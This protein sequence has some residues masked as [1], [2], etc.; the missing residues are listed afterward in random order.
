MKFALVVTALV[1]VASI[2]SA[3][4]PVQPP[5]PFAASVDQLQEKLGHPAVPDTE[6]SLTSIKS[7]IVV[8]KDS[9]AAHEIESAIR[10]IESLGGKI[11]ERYTDIYKG[12]TAKIPF[13][14][15][16]D[17]LTALG[18]FNFI[19]YYEEDGEVSGYV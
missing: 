16:S 15:L 4:L 19:D 8:F 10:F 3:A 5:N 13:A 17:A 1:A 11:G 12:F 6:P 7:Y 18:K 9:A 14:K 2:A